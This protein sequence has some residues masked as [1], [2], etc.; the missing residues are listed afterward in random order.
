MLI[1]ESGSG[2]STKT[3]KGGHRL[4]GGVVLTEQA[5]ASVRYQ[6]LGEASCAAGA[7]PFHGPFSWGGSDPRPVSIKG[8]SPRRSPGKHLLLLTPGLLLLLDFKGLPALV[9]WLHSWAL[10]GLCAPA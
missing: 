9:S 2:E 6:G 5:T 1:I 8:A 3:S 7:H 10:A 4:P